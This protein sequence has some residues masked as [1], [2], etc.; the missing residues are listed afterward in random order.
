MGNK[1]KMVE[2]VCTDCGE[3][4]T[5]KNSDI[6][7]AEANDNPIL[8]IDCEL[9]KINN[10]EE[11]FEEEEIEESLFDDDDFFPDNY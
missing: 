2:A 3:V 5:A 6:K 1:I 7:F 10:E 11:S 9:D 8:C 4:F